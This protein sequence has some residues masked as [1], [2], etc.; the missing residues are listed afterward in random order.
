MV[1]PLPGALAS[2]S[3][4]VMQSH[5][6]SSLLLG[7]NNMLSRAKWKP[8]FLGELPTQL[9]FGSPPGKAGS[10][11]SQQEASGAGTGSQLRKE[12]RWERFW[13]ATRVSAPPRWL[14]RL[15]WDFTISDKGCADIRLRDEQSNSLQRTSTLPSSLTKPHTP[16]RFRERG[17]TPLRPSR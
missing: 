17:R 15:G 2:V 13:T 16:R 12:A 7:S 9:S 11:Y 3:T 1:S 8:T 5:S 4:S 14:T 10:T 6:Q